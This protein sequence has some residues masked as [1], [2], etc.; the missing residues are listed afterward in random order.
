MSRRNL[1]NF[2]LFQCAWFAAVGGAAAG[3]PWLGPAVTLAWLSLH[4][5]FYSAARVRDTAFLFACGAA[6]F[7]VDSALA[8]TGM[9]SFP[10]ASR[11]VPATLW[12]LSTLWMAALWVNL[13]MTLNHSL[14]W[15]QPRPVA[16]L[17][18]GL[19]GGP[20]AYYAGGAMGAVLLPHGAV[21]LLAVGLLWGLAMPALFY[22]CH[23]Y[24]RQDSLS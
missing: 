17:A 22:C 20:A 23:R 18:L 11:L 5:R 19:V 10:P 7:A 12:P 21:S 16:A 2:A 1:I 4:L 13:G 9:L 8:L 6:G 14:A 3:R 15:L 24:A